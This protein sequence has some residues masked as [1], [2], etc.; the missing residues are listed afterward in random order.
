[1]MFRRPMIFF[2]EVMWTVGSSS[3]IL[4]TASPI[5]CKSRSTALCRII[6]SLKVLKLF[7]VLDLMDSISPMAYSM[8][9]IYFRTLGCIQVNFGAIDLCLE[10]R[11]LE[12]FCGNQVDAA[13][14]Q[15]LQGPQQGKIVVRIIQHVNGRGKLNQKINV[16]VRPHGLFSG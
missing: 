16:A 12:G 4:R 2:A 13:F 15:P 8:S 6:S 7:P 10:H 5:I 1:M 9:R 11:V 3:R 14:Q